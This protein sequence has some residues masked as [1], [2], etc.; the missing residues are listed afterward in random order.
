MQ[1]KRGTYH[2]NT[3]NIADVSRVCLII[4]VPTDV[5]S[6]LL[7]GG[8][9]LNAQVAGETRLDASGDAVHDGGVHRRSAQRRRGT[10]CNMVMT[11]TWLVKSRD[12]GNRGK[13]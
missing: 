10:S 8:L 13:A 3:R 5:R 11:S 4:A 2:A 6:D 1:G 7:E 9:G 12:G